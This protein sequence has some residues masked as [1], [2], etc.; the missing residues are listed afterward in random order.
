MH[1]DRLT[2]QS[3]CLMWNPC[4]QFSSTIIISVIESVMRTFG[5]DEEVE[6]STTLTQLTEQ[7]I[8]LTLG[9]CKVQ[10]AHGFIFSKLQLPFTT[11]K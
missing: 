1:E 10:R 11:V 7:H 8:I 4:K 6:A 9:S 2:D 3:F 5:L